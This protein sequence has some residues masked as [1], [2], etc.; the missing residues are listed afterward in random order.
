[1]LKIVK[2]N[3]P[4]LVERINV[5]IYGAPG[6]GKT[7]L[8][9][10]AEAPLLLDFDGGAYRAANRKDTQVIKKWQDVAAITTDDMAPYKTI[11]VDTAGRGLD[12][13]T[14]DI[15]QRDPKM[16]RGG[17][18]T[19]QGYGQL[20]ALFQAWLK[21]L[22]SLG[23]DVL[24]LAHLDEQRSGDDVI[25]RLD[26]QGSSK[27]E[28]YKTSDAMGRIILQGNKRY[29]DFSPRPFAFGKNPANLPLI[30]FPSPAV[31]PDTLAKVITQIK[32]SINKL[33]AEQK[34]AQQLI[35]EWAQFLGGLT[36][37]DIETLNSNLTGL[38]KAPL[39]VRSQAGKR[40]KELGWKWNKSSALFE[41]TNAATA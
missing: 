23:K 25:E 16:G 35:E 20:K 3:E 27:A 29:I 21:M 12:F 38:K 6:L 15:I 34:D 24:L 9:F 33:S 26:I 11:M 1:M 32:A 37:K 18:L 13:L 5:C 30:E 22:N 39:A 19:L 36:A 17:S 7:S 31:Q 28:I 8:G 10:T 41:V 2:A 14:Q 4:M 40:A